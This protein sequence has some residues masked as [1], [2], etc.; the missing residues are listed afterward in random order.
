MPV[1][2]DTKNEIPPNGYFFP[3][4][5]AQFWFTS[6][7]YLTESPQRSQNR[8]GVSASNKSETI[9]QKEKHA[10]IYVKLMVITQCKWYVKPKRPILGSGCPTNVL[11]LFPAVCYCQLTRSFAAS[12]GF[13]M[14]HHMLVSFLGLYFPV[15]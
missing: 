1:I 4:F 9:R 15:P 13:Q 10:K 14:N 3:G 5:A 8:T 2:C 11:L 7:S 12:L 6:L